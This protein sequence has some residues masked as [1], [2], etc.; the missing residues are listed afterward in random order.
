MTSGA[1]ATIAVH[2][3]QRRTGERHGS[4]SSRRMSSSAA[5]AASRTISQRI[6]CVEVDRAAAGAS[7][8]GSPTLWEEMSRS[9]ACG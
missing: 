9:G 8:I 3:V 7:R 1:L 4:R 5:S 6:H 2:T